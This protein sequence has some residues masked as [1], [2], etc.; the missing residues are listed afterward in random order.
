MKKWQKIL[1]ALL[2]IV[3]LFLT[4]GILFL[5][6]HPTFGGSPT[7]EQKELYR[8]FD[9][10]V[11]G[12][13]VNMNEAELDMD[14][15]F[16][17]IFSLLRDAISGVDDQH[18]LE[19]IPIA[20][21]DW[22]TIKNEEDSLTWFGHSNFLLS[23]DNKKILLDP[24]FGNI[25]SPVS[26]IGSTRF[27][28]DIL[29]VMEELPPIDAVFITHDHYDHLD[30][31]SILALKDKVEHFFVPHGIDAHLLRWGVAS[32]RITPMNW[33]DELEWKGL[34]IASVPAHHYSGRGLFDRNSRLW[35][36]W[37]ILGEETRVFTSGDSGYAPHFKKIGE[38]YGPF[39]LT[40]IEGG[41]YDERWSDNHMFPEES[42]QAHLDVNGETMMLMHW[43]AFSLAYHGWSEPV[44]RAL[45]EAEAQDVNIIAPEIGETVLLEELPV[46]VSSWWE[47]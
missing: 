28:D 26:F 34:T 20:T 2:G 33:W 21:F 16:S 14:M 46:P 24:M 13:F 18:P 25:A 1:I 36:G 22:E 4:A 42:V 39:D 47:Y 10:Y 6:L 7:N 38:V 23:I 19:A 44:E 35:S 45:L 17:T 41:Q 15:D 8:Q 27:S 3:L 11:D 29:D 30:Y 43:G 31:P 12:D 5:Q 40:L 37:V 9:N 32:E